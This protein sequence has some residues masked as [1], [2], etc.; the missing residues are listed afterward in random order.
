MYSTLHV[1]FF[2]I[3]ICG[4]KE[5]RNYDFANEINSNLADKAPKYFET[6]WFSPAERFLWIPKLIVWVL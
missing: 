4:A 1:R 3:S 2:L 5:Q 6:D